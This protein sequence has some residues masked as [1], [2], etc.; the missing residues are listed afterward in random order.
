MEKSVLTIE[1]IRSAL[2]E[3][4]KDSSVNRIWLFGSYARNEADA[5][6]DLDIIV[7]LEDPLDIEISDSI[8]DVKIDP[9]S[10]SLFNRKMQSDLRFNGGF[11][12]RV[13]NERV[14]VYEAENLHRTKERKFLL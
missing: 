12:E 11:V 13:L 14:L 8:R 1:E 2:A 10:L 9:M 4:C 5:K 6:S 7:D 3:I